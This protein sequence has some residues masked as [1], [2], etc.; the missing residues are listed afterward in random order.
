MDAYDIAEHV[1][2]YH[3][4]NAYAP[5]RSELETMG[6]DVDALEKN[7]VIELLANRVGGPRIYVRLTDKGLRMAIEAPEHRR[8]TRKR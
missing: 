8:R 7:G 2:H 5:R 6:A 1:R 4:K 3:A